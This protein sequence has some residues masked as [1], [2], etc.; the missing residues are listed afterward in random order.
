MTQLKK[1]ANQLLTCFS[2]DELQKI[3][4]DVKLIQRNRQFSLKHLLWLCVFQ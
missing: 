1:L 2:E 4:A 3:A